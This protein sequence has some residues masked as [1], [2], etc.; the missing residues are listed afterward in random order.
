VGFEAATRVFGD[1]F[2]IFEQDR[3]VDGDLRWQAIGKASEAVLLL[4]AHAYKEEDDE[5][6]IQ[7]I[8]ARKATAR[9]AEA[10]YA[11]FHEGR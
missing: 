1:P 5:E 2:V 9:E 10:Y 8:S 4:V 6:R 11:Q 3:E 7:I